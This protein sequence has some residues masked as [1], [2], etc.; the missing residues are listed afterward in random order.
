MCWSFL[1][2]DKPLQVSLIIN[3]DFKLQFWK[4]NYHISLVF[5]QDTFCAPCKHIGY[6]HGDIRMIKIR[7]HNLIHSYM[8]QTIF[9]FFGNIES[10]S[11]FHILPTNSDMYILHFVLRKMTL[12]SHDMLLIYQGKSTLS[13]FLSFIL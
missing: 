2:L 11:Y 12:S 6:N 1:F 8:D 3:Y 4:Q 9:F 10:H 7:S 13:H 5:S